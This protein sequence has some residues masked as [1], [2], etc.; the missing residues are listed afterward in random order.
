MGWGGAYLVSGNPGQRECKISEGDHEGEGHEHDVCR[1]VLDNEN[2]E[3]IIKDIEKH[4]R[5]AHVVAEG[6]EESARVRQVLSEVSK[7]EGKA[8]GK[9]NNG[10][11]RRG[12]A[13]GPLGRTVE[14]WQEAR[15][16]KKAEGLGRTMAG[17]S[18]GGQ[19]M[20]PHDTH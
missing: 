3:D 6:N 14:R 1:A 8:G 12:K 4:C 20:G 5:H 10:R 13:G 11:R 18:K 16:E 19:G 2:H 15:I 7:P 17:G 9:W